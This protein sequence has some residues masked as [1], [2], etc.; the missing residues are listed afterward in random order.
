MTLEV[1]GNCGFSVAP[2]LPG[3]VAM[4]RE[5]L[6]SSVTWLPFHDTTF[7]DYV[8]GFRATS[9]ECDPPGRSQHAPADDSGAG[10]PPA[11][12]CAGGAGVGCRERRFRQRG[13][14]TAYAVFEALSVAH[15][16][17]PSRRAPVHAEAMR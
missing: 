12:R 6:A 2:A 16:V 7:A 17:G 8:A 5:Y 13:L 15:M 3:K 4:L 11:H 14:Y 1:A 9:V 10:Q